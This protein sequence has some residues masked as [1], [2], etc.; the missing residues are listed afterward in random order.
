[1][2]RSAHLGVVLAAAWLC[3]LATAQAQKYVPFEEYGPPT[4]DPK[5]SRG[6]GG[7]VVGSAGL[8]IATLNLAT[9][10]ICQASFY[11]DDARTTCRALS[12][13]FASVATLVAIPALSI[14]I[15]KR[16]RYKA[17]KARRFPRVA[18]LPTLVPQPQGATLAIHGRF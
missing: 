3:P 5:P 2:S 6:I 15:V 17:W 1:M 9:L 8:F 11:P 14:G 18:A 4:A 16:R 10:P 13:G 12:F 7:L